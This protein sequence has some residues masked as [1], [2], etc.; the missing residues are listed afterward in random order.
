MYMNQ[1]ILALMV[2]S[3][4]LNVQEWKE[5]Q[6]GRLFDIYPTKA[7]AGMSNDELND[8]GA[9]PFII[10][11]AE[12]NGIGGFCSLPATEKG[13]IITFS[14][15]TDGNTFFYQ[16]NDFIGFA[17]VQGMHPKGRE[18]NKY[19]MIFMT[20]ILMFHNRGLFNYGRKMRRDVISS[21]FVKVPVQHNEDGSLVI[22]ANKK[23]SDDGYVPDWEFMENYIKSL[24]S[25]PIT[26]KISGKSVPDLDVDKWEEFRVGKLFS[27]I[28]KAKAHTKDEVIE[29]DRGIHFVS[30]TDTNNG[31]D[32]VVKNDGL[33]GVEKANCITIG[34]TTATCYYQNEDYVTGDHMVVL[35]AEWMN[36]YTGLF[37]RTIIMQEYIRY[38]YGRA[39][40]MD[41]IKNTM[42]KLPIQRDEKGNP[43]ID[44]SK[45]YSEKGYIPDWEF[46]ENYIKTLPYSDRI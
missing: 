42:I 34:D 11:S 9:T 28:Y 44:N 6:I 40:R 41:L 1:L 21:T 32:I 16:P 8:G 17:H 2:N 39:Y 25:Q 15:T 19:Q 45:K 4:E 46:M 24:H 5:I 27:N 18:W 7:Y 14:D 43:I 20:A 36:M 35:R 26:T 29:T 13:N 10:N 3:M 38:C 30:R 12:N 22:D 23:Y 37:I 31:V 33:E